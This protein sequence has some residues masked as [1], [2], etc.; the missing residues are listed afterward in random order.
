M[1]HRTQHATN[2]TMVIEVSIDKNERNKERASERDGWIRP[3]LVSVIIKFACLSIKRRC[4]S[5]YF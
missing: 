1:N 5:S 3:H 2:L 4:S